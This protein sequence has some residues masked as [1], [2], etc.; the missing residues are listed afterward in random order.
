MPGLSV[1]IPVYNCDV[2]A[3]VQALVNQA[4]TWPGP[5]ELLCFDDASAEAFRKLNREIADW[6]GVRYHELP[7]NLGRAAIRNRLA[8]AASHPWLLLLDNNTRITSPDFLARYAAAQHTAPVIVGGSVYSE[9]PPANM[10][11]HLRWHYGRTR[12]ARPAAER[13]QA[14]Y[15][16]FNLKNV[17]ISAAVFR[18]FPL[19]ETLTQYGHEDTK[20]GWQLR[21][22]GVPVHHLPNP[23]EHAVLEPAEEFLAKSQA[24]VRNLLQLYRASG[25]GADTR[26]LS[27]ALRLRHLGLAGVAARALAVAQ[28]WLRHRVLGP[29]PDLRSLD[30]LK[31][32]WLLQA[33]QRPPENKKPT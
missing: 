28:P 24:A 32:L 7:R 11:Q 22:Q 19:D 31:L 14:P 5:L 16:Q 12:E 10:R 3:L 26:L 13:Q 6:P 2:R 30:L 4:A 18:Q 9:T 23:V 25:L 15:A 20:L 1:L 33:W 21:Q 17:L 29:R 8:A 27:T